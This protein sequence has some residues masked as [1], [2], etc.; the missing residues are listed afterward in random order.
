MSNNRLFIISGPSGAGED[1]IIKGLAERM[2]ISKA[3]TTTTREK[4]NG[5]VEGIDYYYITKEKFKKNI[6]NGKMAEYAEHYNKNYYGVTKKEL[7]RIQSSESVGIW[8]IDYK[9]VE[10]AKKMFPGIIAI[11]ITAESLEI[12]EKRLRMRSNVTDEYIQERMTYTRD[13]LNHTDIYDYTVINRQNEL[14]KA[15]DDVENIINYH[16]KSAK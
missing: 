10:Q 14:E 8:K 13:W 9:G 3:I 4:R 7:F 5:E 16:I 11:F 12:L 1:S 2:N 6:D 15:I